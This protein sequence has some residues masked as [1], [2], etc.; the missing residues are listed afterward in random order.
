MERHEWV[1]M[2]EKFMSDVRRQIEVNGKVSLRELGV[3]TG[4]SAATF[5]RLQRGYLPDMNTF[6][7]ICA[8]LDLT[9]GDY[10][11]KVVWKGE[12]ES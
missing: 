9:P 6:T 8:A 7:Q 12:F 10:F 1:F 2:N 11:R 4:I 3:N 5:S